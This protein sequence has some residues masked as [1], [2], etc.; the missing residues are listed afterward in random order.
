MKYNNLLINSYFK[1]IELIF[2][3]NLLNIYY[4]I[5]PKN[6]FLL[7]LDKLKKKNNIFFQKNNMV[8]IDFQTMWSNLVILGWK[9]QGI[10][11]LLLCQS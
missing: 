5:F 10:R 4:R 7:Y 3:K 11:E 2:V 6:L 1:N 9:S 8:S